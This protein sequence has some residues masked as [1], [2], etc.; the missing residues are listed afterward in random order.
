M[1]VTL[2][3]DGVSNANL[4]ALGAEFNALDP[5]RT[6][7]FFDDFYFIDSAIAATPADYRA[8]GVNPVPPTIVSGQF[9]RAVFAPAAAA[10]STFIQ[11][12][13]NPTAAAGALPLTFFPPQFTLN[14]V[15]CDLW[16]QTLFQISDAILSTIAAGFLPS[17][18]AAGDPLAAAD[19]IFFTK[20][21]GTPILS[22][23]AIKTAVGNT[24]VP[25]AT[26]ANATDI[27]VG[28]HYSYNAGLIYIFV[29]DVG[30]GSMSA[31]N[32]PAVGLLPLIG[33]G[34]NTAAR[35]SS[36]DYLFA[37]QSRQLENVR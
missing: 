19:G 26:L 9:G 29:N 12:T 3:P 8:L 11:P 36:W 23:K 13:G 7:S 6:S 31:A 37:A 5:T 10:D 14:A 21:S 27:K 4:G 15:K 18:A 25:V 20:A 1:T 33:H 17:V 30:V 16:F 34:N 35:T 28:F 32:I 2:L 24:V 22:L